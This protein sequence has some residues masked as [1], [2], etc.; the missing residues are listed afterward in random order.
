MRALTV[1]A[2]SSALAPGATRM[3]MAAIGWPFMRA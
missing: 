2:T 3:A 1:F